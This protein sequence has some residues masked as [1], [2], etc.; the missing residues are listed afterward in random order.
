MVYLMYKIISNDKHL[1]LSFWEKGG[2]EG[3]E[4]IHESKSSNFSCFTLYF[5]NKN[6]P[7]LVGGGGREVLG[8]FYFILGS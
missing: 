2:G 1:Y 3:E 5:T 4:D 7:R 8:F 6:L